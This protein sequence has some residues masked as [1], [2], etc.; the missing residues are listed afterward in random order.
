[1][2]VHD[3]PAYVLHQHDWSESSLILELFTRHHG[4]VVL[5]GKGVKRPT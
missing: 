5:V 4:R 2:R 3:E 1:M